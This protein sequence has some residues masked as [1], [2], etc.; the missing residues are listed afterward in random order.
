MK[1][2]M[3]AFI[4][5]VLLASTLSFSQARATDEN[6]DLK[7]DNEQAI[8]NSDAEVEDA[9]STRELL[10]QEQQ[11]HAEEAIRLKEEI[12]V[13][14]ANE[15]A[16]RKER[17]QNEKTIARLQKETARANAELRE[18]KKVE[19]KSQQKLK[20]AEAYTSRTQR[21]RD[22]IVKK[23]EAAVARMTERHQQ[24]QQM[25]EKAKQAWA[26]Y[27]TA[28]AQY[29]QALQ[30]EK[31]QKLALEKKKALLKKKM[32]EIQMKTNK[33]KAMT[34]KKAEQNRAG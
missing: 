25:A 34:A 31:A 21:S 24:A 20:V 29:R 6:F 9:T 19:S 15:I 16:A 10:A 27:K 30:H 17:L 3:T 14:R 32:S 8:A 23:K 1:S 12:R 26:D 13:A 4:S 2:S 11:R 7:I 5:L 28:E 18:A 22:A 33:L